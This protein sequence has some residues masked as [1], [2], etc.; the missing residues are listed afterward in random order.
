LLKKEG[1]P[2]PVYLAVKSILSNAF[3]TGCSIPVD[4]GRR[5]SKR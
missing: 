1:G 3:L 4:G 2:E 5:L